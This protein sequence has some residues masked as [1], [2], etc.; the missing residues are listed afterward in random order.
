MRELQGNL[1]PAAGE[2][3][4]K[5]FLY[6]LVVFT[7]YEQLYYLP[8]EEMRP[9]HG[10]IDFNG[11]AYY[12]WRPKQLSKQRLDVTAIAEMGIVTFTD[13]CP[14]WVKGTHYS[15]IKST[16]PD[17]VVRAAK[18]E[19]PGAGFVN[20]EAFNNF[21][22][23]WGKAQGYWLSE[24]DAMRCMSRG[25]LTQLLSVG[26][27]VL[28]LNCRGQKDTRLAWDYLT[29][30]FEQPELGTFLFVEGFRVFCVEK[31]LPWS[32]MH[33]RFWNVYGH[34]FS[35]QSRKFE[36]PRLQVDPFARL[37][38]MKIV[39]DVLYAKAGAKAE[40]PV[41]LVR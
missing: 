3:L 39:L 41:S 20:K 31:G 40:F 25:L 19:L 30:L 1:M 37:G 7:F 18:K 10:T 26:A 9:L 36:T 11:P 35:E 38:V 32:V 28:Y 16:L 24:C 29:R 34:N 8:S 5:T 15:G 21:A 33:S 12:A 17:F 23:E 13:H 27:H 22:M 6:D 14:L 2:A 4:V